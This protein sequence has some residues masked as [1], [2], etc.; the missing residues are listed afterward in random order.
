MYNIS[1]WDSTK[2]AVFFHEQAQWLTLHGTLKFYNILIYGSRE[3]LAVP[4]PAQA[5]ITEPDKCYLS[6]Q[7]LFI[8]TALHLSSVDTDFLII[9]NF[10]QFPQYLVSFSF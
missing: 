5:H 4:G 8:W 6:P 9:N 10:H 7:M 1:N 2:F 3:T